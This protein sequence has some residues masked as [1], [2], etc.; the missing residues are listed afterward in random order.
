MQLMKTVNKVLEITKQ[1]KDKY[2]DMDEFKPKPRGMPVLYNTPEEYKESLR[3][4][5]RTHNMT[6][7]ENIVEQTKNYVKIE[8]QNREKPLFK[9]NI[10]II[11]KR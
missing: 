10:T 7:Q 8:H 9:D 5:R 2:E 1:N 3:H 11:M 6:T 4:Y